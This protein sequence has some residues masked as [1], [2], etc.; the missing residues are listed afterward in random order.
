MDEETEKGRKG[1]RTFTRRMGNKGKHLKHILPH[2]PEKY[3][4]YI[5]PFLGTGAVFL[6]IKPKKFIINDLNRDVMD[7]W[8]SVRDHPPN[9]LIDCFQEFGDVF[10]PLSCS[11]K[12]DMCHQLVDLMNRNEQEDDSVNLTPLDKTV[13]YILLTYCSYMG[14][15]RMKNRYAIKGIEYNIYKH[16]RYS[17]L[18]PDYELNLNRI[19]DW[20]STSPKHWMQNKDYKSILHKSKKGDF[21]FLDPPYMEDHTYHF[22]YN[23]G[24]KDTLIPSFLDELVKELKMLDEKGVLWMMTQ[25]STPQVRQKFLENTNYHC[26][27]Y[28]VFR[29]GTRGYAKE[30]I[31]RNYE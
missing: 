1:L 16:N 22:E 23:S 19:H 11:Q 18:T 26:V 15:V 8:E 27:E 20:L 10:R 9:Y 12:L 3:N 24:E 29:I 17:F 30:C 21:V 5:E 28:T 31:I 13:F 14:T 6:A 2:I 7:T 4:R 25:A